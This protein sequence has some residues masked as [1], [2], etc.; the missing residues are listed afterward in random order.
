[1]TIPPDSTDSITPN[2]PIKTGPSSTA[3]AGSGFQSYMTD[4]GQ[5]AKGSGAPQGALMGQQA[6]LP[7]AGTPSLDTLAAQ[8]GSSQDSMANV[9]NQLD[10]LKNTKL[11]RSQTHLVRNKL[12]DAN[13]HLRAA[14]SKMGAE[15]PDAPPPSGHG[16]IA[17]FLSY[18]TD[19]ENQL[20]AARQ[21][22][23]SLAKSG[24][25][26]RPADML[27]VQIKLNQAEQEISYAS[28]LLNKVTSSINQILSTQL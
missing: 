2:Q 3:P 25:Q 1:M 20:A 17:K 28:M 13:T 26:L 4:Q 11:T 15:T 16:P 22:L 6:S 5:A 23:G 10:K 8:I 7:L 24:D 9:R 12:T 27:L 14:N 18:V 21:K 19:G